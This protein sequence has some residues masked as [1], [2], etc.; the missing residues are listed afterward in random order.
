[1]GK[2]TQVAPIDKLSI[3]ITMILAFVILK[4]TVTVK[5]VVGGILITLGTLAMIL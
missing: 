1:M 3:V 2:V 5:T 4:E